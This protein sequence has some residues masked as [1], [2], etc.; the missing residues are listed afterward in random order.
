MRTGRTIWLVAIGTLL[1][2]LV[3]GAAGAQGSGKATA[4]MEDKEGNPVGTAD[5]AQGPNGVG[6][7]VNVKDLPPGEHAIHVHEKGKITPDFEAAGEHYNPTKAKHGFNNPEGPHASDLENINIAEDG[8]AS[9]ATTAPLLTVNGPEN[10]LLDADGSALVIHEKADDYETDPSGE[11]GNRI[12]AGVIKE[13]V[14]GETTTAKESTVSGPL[15]GSGGPDIL[16]LAAIAAIGGVGLLLLVL[17]PRR[18]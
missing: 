8:T 17:R 9:Y 13:A 10:A 7:S 15:P 1:S 12:A 11:S 14:T 3:A 16:L 18:T 5:F 6:I 2:I 4:K